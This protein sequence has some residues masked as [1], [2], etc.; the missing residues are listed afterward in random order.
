[1]RIHLVI[2]L[3]L[4]IMLG[5]CVTWHPVPSDGSPSATFVESGERRGLTWYQSFGLSQVDGLYV[6]HMGTN[7]GSAEVRVAPGTR[8]LLI[9]V[10]FLHRDG[11]TLISNPSDCPC[12]A[13]FLIEMDLRAGQRIEIGGSI[14]QN[15]LVTLRL[16]DLG[17]QQTYPEL[18]QGAVPIPKSGYIPLPSGGYIP[19]QPPR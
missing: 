1:M 18:K 4:V 8:K 10:R 17:A 11:L 7:V 5:G 16:S 15:R 19:I 2:L 3:T 13:R 12:E 14:D 6:S 9:R